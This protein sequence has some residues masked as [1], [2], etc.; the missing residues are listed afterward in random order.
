MPLAPDSP[1]AAIQGSPLPLGHPLQT[2]P[3]LLTGA[4]SHWAPKTGLLGLFLPP[5]HPVHGSSGYSS[6]HRNRSAALQH[7][8]QMSREAR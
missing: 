7:T 5:P 6:Y 3:G 4:N 1:A 2:H 8:E